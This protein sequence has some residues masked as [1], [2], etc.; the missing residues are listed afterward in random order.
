LV[1]SKNKKTTEQLDY[2][3]HFALKRKFYSTLN[4]YIW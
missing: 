2:K 1:F 3:G 4:W